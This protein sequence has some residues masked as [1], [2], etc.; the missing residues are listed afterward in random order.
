QAMKGDTAYPTQRDQRDLRINRRQLLEQYKPAAPTPGGNRSLTVRHN[1]GQSRTICS[2]LASGEDITGL[3][4]SRQTAGGRRERDS[5]GA[6]S[7]GDPTAFCY[8]WGLSWGTA[9]RLQS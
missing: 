4:R 7:W 2:A 8:T 3:P 5:L 6:P 9:P 1:M